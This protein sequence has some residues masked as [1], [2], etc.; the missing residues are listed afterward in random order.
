MISNLQTTNK[1]FLVAWHLVTQPYNNTKIIAMMHAKHLCQMPPVKKGDPSSLR[2]LI[3]L[4]IKPHKYPTGINTKCS[5]SGFALNHLS[6]NTIDSDTQ[7]EWVRLFT[8]SRTDVPTTAEL[9]TFVE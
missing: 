2:K 6:L 8:A 3:N 5:Y 7:R 9:I 4:V 1:K